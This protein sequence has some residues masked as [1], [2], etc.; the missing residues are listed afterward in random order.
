MDLSLDPNQVIE[1]FRDPLWIRLAIGVVILVVGWL[2]ALVASAVTRRVTGGLNVND[3]LAPKQVEEDG[4]ERPGID[5]ER[6]LTQAVFYV[7]MLFT[8]VAFFQQLEIPAI[9]DPLNAFLTKLMQDFL[10]QIIGAGLILLV[11]W[12]VASFVKYLVMQA[13]EISRIDDRLIKQADLGEEQPLSAS[14]SLA[15]AAYWL[16]F[17]LFLPTVFGRL[18]M[19]E[20]AEPIQLITT[21]I[22]G[23]LP[24]AF[25]AGLILVIG[26]FLARIARQVVTNLLE[27]AGI[28]ELGHRAGLIG[29]QSLSALLGTMLYAVIMILVAIQSLKALGIDTISEPATNMLNTA[30]QAI[31]NLVAAG[32]LIAVAYYAGRLVSGLAASVLEGLGFDQLP[33]RLGLETVP[34]AGE[35]SPSQLAG[36]LILVAIVLFAAAEAASLLG[37]ALIVEALDQVIAF[38]GQLFLAGVILAV[39]LYLA[40]LAHSAVLSAGGAN[41][42]RVAWIVR[43][44]IIVLVAA[45]ALEHI[46]VGQEI[47]RDAFRALVFAIAAAAAIAFGLGGR[48]SASQEIDRW[49]ATRREESPGTEPM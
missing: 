4:T 40:N 5:L 24:F 38:G 13:G 25:A 21:R 41:A 2:V 26:W 34:A 32:L 6:L 45:M 27:V 8:L 3:R 16:V 10:P 44:A 29:D 18:Q 35:R 28:D 7:V 33:G 19:S 39:G 11:A 22:L 37:F 1:F 15:T 48:D 49:V 20:L 23:F 43:A 36:L 9:T 31:P 30:F 14:S 12:I 47:V 42:E 17:L 46:Q